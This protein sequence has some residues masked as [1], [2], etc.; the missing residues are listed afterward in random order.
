MLGSERFNPMNDLAGLFGQ[1]PKDTAPPAAQF[2]DWLPYSAYFADEKVFV[3]RDGM[4]FMLEVVP[5]SGADDRMAEVL[6]SLYSRCPVGTGIQF[7]L[8]ASPH[9]RQQLVQY[10]NLR[11]EDTDQTEKAQHWGRPARNSNLS[12]TLARKRVEH[13]LRA[14]HKSLTSGFHYTLRDFRLMMSVSCAGDPEVLTEREDLIA[15]RESMASTLRSASLPNRVC[16]ASDLINWC[17]PFLNPGLLSRIESSETPP[18]VYDNGREIRD[19]I[20]DRDTIQDAR[21]NSIRMWKENSPDVLEASFYSIKS[22]PE[23]FSLWQM[24]SLIGDLMQPALQYT[25]PFLLTLGVRILDPNATKSVV[26]ANHLRA[27]QNARSKMAEAM[28]DVAKKLQDWTAAAQAIDAG[29]N[30]VSLYHQLAIFSPPEQSATV[31]EAANAIWRSRGFQLNADVY[32][33]RQA[34]LASLPMTLTERFHKDLAK[35]RRV[36]RK[37]MANAVHLAPLIGEWRGTKTPTLI[38]AGRRGQ[39]TTL[40]VFDNDLGNPTGSILGTPGSGK[41]VLMNE[42]AWSYHAVGAK[43][44]MLDYGR[45]FEKLCRKANGTYIEFRPETDICLNMFSRIV[46]INEDIDMLLQVLSK[47]ATMSHVLEE[48]QY[49]ALSAMCLKKFKEYGNDLTVTG[50][51][52][53]FKVGTIDELGIVNDSRIK[54]LAI[55]LNPYCRGGPYERYFEGHCSIDFSNDFIVI[56]SEE[57]KRRRDLQAVVNVLLLHQITGEMYLTRNRR[58]VLFIDELKQQLGGGSQDDPVMAAVIEEAAR[59]ARKFGGSLITATHGADD[60][61]GS[62]QMEAAFNCSDWVFMLRQKPESIELL[63]RKGRLAVDESKKRLLNSLRTEP[64]AFSEI[65][66]SSPMGEGVVRNILDPATQLLFSNKLEDNAPLD[67]LRSQGMS[68]DEAIAT[69]LRMRGH[70]Q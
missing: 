42:M 61:Y 40:D 9:I 8:F 62:A 19:Q 16:D 23:R 36:T 1:E 47:M 10:A 22:L 57:L 31:Q 54:D 58:K 2:A 34:L 39:L 17:A 67:E 52:D 65:Y 35:M 18:V 70:I 38:F 68:I 50:L 20:V 28:P 56:E 27:S 14:A 53:A 25:A 32:M 29:N 41:S 44:W 15:L 6:I 3:N 59:R 11:K 48:V 24:G 13:L 21:P 49:K 37:T 63:S 51:R 7:H 30:L 12:R 60:Y 46:D 33:Q 26:T 45:S 64:G 43:V 69:L 55:M 4:G 5:Q 66:I